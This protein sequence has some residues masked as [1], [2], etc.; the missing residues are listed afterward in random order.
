MAH[1]KHQSVRVRYAF[2]CGYCG[3]SETDAGGEMTVDHFHPQVHGG[4]E[5]DDN[6]VY[7]CFRCNTYKGDLL[8][9]D[10]NRPLEHRLLHP[11]HDNFNDHIRINRQTGWLE[12]LTVTGAFHMDALH[13]NRAALIANRKRRRHY[14]RLLAEADQT[15]ADLTRRGDIQRLRDAY[16]RVLKAQKEREKEQGNE[17][18]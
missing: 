3:I 11:L 1:F 6:L 2:C 4:D 8:P 16:V 7:A 12:A 18:E 13:L 9:Q 15:Y 17:E 5:S 14:A 10:A